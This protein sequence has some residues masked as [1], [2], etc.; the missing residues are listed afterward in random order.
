MSITTFCDLD[1]NDE[2]DSLEILNLCFSIW[3]WLLY[4]TSGLEEGHQIALMNGLC[5]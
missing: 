4:S 2:H 3:K 1:D 5:E